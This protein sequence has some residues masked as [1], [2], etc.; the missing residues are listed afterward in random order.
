MKDIERVTVDD[1]TAKELTETLTLPDDPNIIA[2]RLRNNG[3]S[4]E[5]FQEF[6]KE[7]SLEDD[8]EVIE[9]LKALE[10]TV[11]IYL[12]A[13]LFNAGQRLH[14]LFLEKHLKKMGHAVIL[15]QREVL[16]H[17]DGKRFNLDAIVED[18]KQACTNPENICVACVDGSDADSGTVIEYGMT[19]VS[20]GR[21]VIYRTDFRTAEDKEVGVNAMLKAKRTEFIYH[22]CFFT[23]LDEVEAYYQ[24]LALKIHE[25]VIAVS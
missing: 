21:A 19:I 23:E 16:K 17:F 15:P 22:P 3:A 20:T 5:S 1:E 10:K 24:E 12:A 7:N 14:N 11:T 18:C 4:V 25:A 13:G 2:Q 9:I 8:P 6:M